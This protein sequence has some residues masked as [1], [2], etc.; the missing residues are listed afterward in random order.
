M[1]RQLD[2]YEYL[3]ETLKYSCLGIDLSLVRR[4]DAPRNR[5]LHDQL[6][7]EALV[8]DDG[9]VD[10]DLPVIFGSRHRVWME[11]PA[12]IVADDLRDADLP[13]FL[14]RVTLGSSVFI[15]LEPIE[16]IDGVV[17]GA[18]AGG[19]DDNTSFPRLVWARGRRSV[20][21][22]CALSDWSSGNDCDS[23]SGDISVVGSGGGSSSSSIQRS[24]RAFPLVPTSHPLASVFAFLMREIE[25]HGDEKLGRGM[26]RE[27]QLKII[28]MS[29][30]APRDSGEW[31]EE[32]V[33]D[34]V[35]RLLPSFANMVV[36]SMLDYDLRGIVGFLWHRGRWEELSASEVWFRFKLVFAYAEFCRRFDEKILSQSCHGLEIADLSR[37]Q[38]VQR[39]MQNLVVC[40]GRTDALYRVVSVLEPDSPGLRLGDTLN[41]YEAC[42]YDFLYL[43]DHIEFSWWS[44][45]NFYFHAQR[46]S[47]T[48]I[49]RKDFI[50][51][52]TNRWEREQLAMFRRAVGGIQE[53]E[54]GRV[55]WESLNDCGVCIKGLIPYELDSD[56][57][58]E[59]E[60]QRQNRHDRVGRYYSAPAYDFFTELDI[61]ERVAKP[62][63]PKGPDDVFTSG[64]RGD[65]VGVLTGEV[66]CTV[67]N[68]SSLDHPIDVAASIAAVGV[69][70]PQPLSE[71]TNVAD[72]TVMGLAT[73]PSS[74]QKK[75]RR[76][77]PRRRRYCCGLV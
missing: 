74:Y 3:R 12:A 2:A 42:H 48:T 63:G 51:A 33:S 56:A 68:F 24:K 17:D 35:R 66:L 60:E 41:D 57:D 62:G 47:L 16:A 50:C 18:G 61:L 55:A 53:V 58:V 49:L 31:Y 27:T 71:T 65:E 32:R 34:Y 44:I 28:N 54:Q 43:T 9:W 26:P 72:V 10:D 15:Q 64:P 20:D 67:K 75:A 21:L 37:A 76:R 23:N 46:N 40:I 36:G 38:F 4:W 11:T 22:L 73:A 59:S 25:T 1:S 14:R 30:V 77:R 70:Q 8:E 19:G 6:C 13:P 69:H 29:A 45:C 5:G 39:C 7:R 52:V